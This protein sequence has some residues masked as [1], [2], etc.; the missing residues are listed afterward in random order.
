MTDERQLREARSSH[1]HMGRYICGG[2]QS[3]R[4]RQEYG[5]CDADGG[6]EGARVNAFAWVNAGDVDWKNT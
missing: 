3:L 1:S 2:A 6:R 4:K 5:R